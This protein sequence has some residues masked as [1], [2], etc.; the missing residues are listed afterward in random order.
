MK[1]V[2]APLSPARQA[3]TAADAKSQEWPWHPLQM[4]MLTIAVFAVSQFGVA[5]FLIAGGVVASLIAGQG[6]NAAETLLSGSTV[7]QFATILIIESLV[8]LG[9]WWLLRRKGLGLR[10]I[11]VVRPRWADIGLALLALGVY[12]TVFVAIVA[13]IEQYVPGLDTEQRQEIG[14][15]DASNPLQLVLVFTSL[16]ILAPIAEEVLFRGFLFT[17]LRRRLRFVWAALLTSILFG[18]A[19]LLGGEQ[20]ASLLWIAGIDTMVLSIVLCFL[21][22]RTG[23]LW[24]PVLLHAL[25]NCIAFSLLFIFNVA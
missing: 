2:R 5:A 1:T 19:H 16:V 4:I 8:V 3:G 13:I 20:G 14:F 25:K 21:R 10:D 17:G 6:S 9:V 24:A 7:T 23:R 18:A 11:G 15:E 12:F 22:E